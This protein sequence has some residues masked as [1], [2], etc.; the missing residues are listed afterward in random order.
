MTILDDL[1]NVAPGF[2]TERD[3]GDWYCLTPDHER[4]AEGFA[5]RD[6]AR[7]AILY[8]AGADMPAGWKITEKTRLSC[9]LN[10]GQGCDATIWTRNVLSVFPKR[11][12]DLTP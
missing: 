9:G 3:G 2:Y 1:R 10:C 11:A 4:I 8:L 12:T 5:K 7:R 6:D